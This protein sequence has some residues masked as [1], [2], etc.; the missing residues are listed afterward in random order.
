M[1]VRCTTLAGALFGDYVFSIG[2]ALSELESK[3]LLA[4]DRPDNRAPRLRFLSG[5]GSAITATAN[6]RDCDNVTVKVAGGLRGARVIYEIPSDSMAFD[7]VQRPR[8]YEVGPSPPPPEQRCCDRCCW[9]PL[10]RKCL[11]RWFSRP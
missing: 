10:F 9:S 3:I 2:A 5:D 11:S 6:L 7:L 4:F 1:R 8:F